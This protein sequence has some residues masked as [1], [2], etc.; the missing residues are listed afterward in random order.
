MS[1]KVS[2]HAG[3]RFLQRVF[4]FSNYTK[5]E[6]INAI[7]LI[8]KDTQ[9]IQHRSKNFILPSFPNFQAIISEN[10]LVTIIPK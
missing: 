8:S 9:N 2:Y 1:L 4:E 7:K 6:V 10:T 3:E 5:K